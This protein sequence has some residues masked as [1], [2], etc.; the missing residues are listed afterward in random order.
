M[1]TRT[2]AIEYEWGCTDATY[3]SEEALSRV[4]DNDGEDDAWAD[5]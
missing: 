4:W 2:D 1:I 3:L 5:L